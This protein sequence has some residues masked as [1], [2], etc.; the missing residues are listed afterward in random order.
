MRTL[1]LLALVTVAACALARP[2]GNNAPVEPT[3]ARPEADHVKEPDFAESLVIEEEILPRL[4]SEQKAT[5]TAIGTSHSP[6]ARVINEEIRTNEIKDIGDVDQLEPTVIL[7]GWFFSSD[8]VDDRLKAM[9]L[10]AFLEASSEVTQDSAKPPLPLTAT[11]QMEEDDGSDFEYYA[12]DGDKILF[13]VKP[14]DDG[15]YDF[16]AEGDNMTELLVLEETPIE[17]L[18][19]DRG[20]R[21]GTYPKPAG[22]AT[23]EVAPLKAGLSLRKFNLAMS[24]IPANLRWFRIEKHK[25]M[26]LPTESSTD[27]VHGTDDSHFNKYDNNDM[28]TPVYSIILLIAICV[29]FAVAIMIFIF[30]WNA[31]DKKARAAAQVDYPAYGVTGPNMD[32]TGDGSLA[33]SAHIYNYQLQKRQIIAMERSAMEARTL[34]VSDYES[35]DDNEDGDYTVYECPGRAS[36]GN[37]EVKNPMFKDEPTQGKSALER[38]KSNEEPAS[39]ASGMERFKLKRKPKTGNSGVEGPKPKE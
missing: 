16:T 29:A 23:D 34:S 26:K 15:Y 36:M 28:E 11:T 10:R 22:L 24:L 32:F 17:G 4:L 30:S 21:Q 6:T 37:L 33:H 3:S 1:N 7:P 19:L 9:V 39:G 2:P 27:G 20:F 25:P 31:L 8:F 13:A 18:E 38:P 12:M 14:S 35:D 5:G